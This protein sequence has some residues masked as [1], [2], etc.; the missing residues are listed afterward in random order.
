MKKTSKDEKMREKKPLLISNSELEMQED[1]E[2]VMSLT[3]S[4]KIIPH[5]QIWYCQSICVK[6]KRQ[7]ITTEPVQRYL[8]IHNDVKSHAR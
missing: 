4:V 5:F 3:L 8:N 6:L 1:K 2:N 7:P